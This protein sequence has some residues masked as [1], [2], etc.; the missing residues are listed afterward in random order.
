MTATNNSL[1]QPVAMSVDEFSRWAGVGR[2]T[3]WEEIRGRRLR[4]IKVG[5]RTLVTI[6]DAKHWLGTRPERSR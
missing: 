3:A 6:E 5:R 1:I 2:T 4:A